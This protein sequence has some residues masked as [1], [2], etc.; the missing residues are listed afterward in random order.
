MI[1]F[2]FEKYCCG[3]GACVDVCPVSVVSLRQ[4]KG[5][6]LFPVIDNDKC[7]HCG[8]CDCICPHLIRG[9]Q[10]NE[11]KDLYSAKHKDERVR[12]NGSSGS[13]FYALAKSH[14]EHNNGIVIAAGFNVE[15]QLHHQ[16]VKKVEDIAP[17]MKSKYIQSST[18]GIYKEVK[19]LLKES[20][21]VLFV[22][23]PCQC[24]AVMNSVS[25][26]HKELL[27]IVDFVCHGVPSQDLFNRWKSMYE[28][29]HDCR[30]VGVSFREKGDKHIRSFQIDRIDNNTKQ[31]FSHRGLPPEWSYY[32]GFLDHTTFRP[33]CF[34][35]HFKTEDRISDI[36]LGDFWGL[37]SI[38]SGI[39]DFNKGYSMV[40][41]NSSKGKQAI[42]RINQ[43]V[44]F[45]IYPLEVA[46]ENNHA[47][48]KKDEQPKL[49][50]HFLNW[51]SRLP[52]SV[53][54]KLFLTSTPSFFWR[55]FRK[56]FRTI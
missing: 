5:G 25:T 54:D 37:E 11:V 3:C 34:N 10:H 17:M 45:E 23:T 18:I 35:C 6:F 12:L 44:Y 7:T 2:D 46:V 19:S 9:G 43:D 42:N 38:N 40:V 47:F 53:L 28:N 39:K 51:Y 31:L 32:N 55:C 20:I 15:L 13:V 26:Q 33:S 29:Q 16:S 56:V 22:G 1:S 36:T 21:P 4:G 48:A 8:R 49:S 24:Q 27:T 52:M 41:V 50:R 30:V 14:I